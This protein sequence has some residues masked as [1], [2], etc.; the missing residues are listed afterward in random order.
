M[1]TESEML[2]VYNF[3]D[4]AMLID[5][6]I[7]TISKECRIKTLEIRNEVKLKKKKKKNYEKKQPIKL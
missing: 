2:I 7:S 1:D 6:I 3:I 4:T 5:M